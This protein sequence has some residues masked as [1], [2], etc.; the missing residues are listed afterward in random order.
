MTALYVLKEEDMNKKNKHFPP[1]PLE[2]LWDLLED[3]WYGTAAFLNEEY[4]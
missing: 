4:K 1:R 2:R 3:K